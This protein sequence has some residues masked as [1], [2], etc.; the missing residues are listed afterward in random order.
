[1]EKYTQD[2]YQTIRKHGNAELIIEKSR[3][4]CHARPVE[5]LK[6]AKHYIQELTKKY[7]DATHNCYAY[8]ISNLIQKCND[9]GEP[10]GTAG[11]P[12]LKVIT[13]NHLLYTVIIITRYFGGIRLGTGGLTRA[14]SQ[15]ALAAIQAAEI[16]T[17]RLYQE[18]IFIIEY[19]FLKKVEHNLYQAGYPLGPS[20]YNK[21]V[22]KS[23]WSPLGEQQ[24]LIQQVKNWTNGKVE[25]KLGRIKYQTVTKHP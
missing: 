11:Q 8:R 10:S 21:M 2:T 20:Q 6:A 17:K 12:I 25:I 7:Q 18:I 19:T 16:I 5:S 1:M 9:D 3:F 22:K 4:I 15:A 13:T 14:Y 24:T 23:V